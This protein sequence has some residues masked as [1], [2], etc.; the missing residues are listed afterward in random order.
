[1]AKGKI[2]LFFFWFSITA[3]NTKKNNLCH[4]S[5]EATN[6][7]SDAMR[8]SFL[9]REALQKLSDRDVTVGEQLLRQCLKLRRS[10]LYKHH[11]EIAEAEDALAKTLA[12]LGRFSE[13]AECLRNS[14]EIVKER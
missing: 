3:L 8:A 5:K 6:Q 4:Y 2:F 12:S 10:A 7:I 11:E 9:F 13:S 14:L 1:V